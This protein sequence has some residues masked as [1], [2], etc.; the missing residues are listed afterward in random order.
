MRKSGGRTRELCTVQW[1]AT[2][3]RSA[4]HAGTIGPVTR[5]AR[6]LTGLPA[7]MTLKVNHARE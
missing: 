7:R 4:L 3:G 1:E 2:A 5:V 6:L